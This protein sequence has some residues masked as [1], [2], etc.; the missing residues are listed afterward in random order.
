VIEFGLLTGY[1]ALAAWVRSSSR[2][3]SVIITQRVRFVGS[4]RRTPRWREPQ[5]KPKPIR[6]WRIRQRRK[7]AF[8]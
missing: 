4:L 2:Q 3:L 8:L 7:T 5:L 6:N 1:E